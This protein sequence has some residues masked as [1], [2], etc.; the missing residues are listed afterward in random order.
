[1]EKF[2]SEP[3]EP[4][5]ERMLGTAR[6]TSGEDWHHGWLRDY[7]LAVAVFTATI[8]LQLLD[9]S[10]RAAGRVA[11]PLAVL[12]Q[13]S[14]YVCSFALVVLLVAAVDARVWR[15]LPPVENR[16]PNFRGLLLP[17]TVVVAWFLTLAVG[18]VVFDGLESDL[19]AAVLFGVVGN[20]LAF[21]GCLVLATVYGRRGE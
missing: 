16:T 21:C 6:I 17:A 10:A 5:A 4:A 3:V 15:R 8:P 7:A 12:A 20:A 18:E 2:I 14:L 11:E 19:V 13:L 1:M 9:L